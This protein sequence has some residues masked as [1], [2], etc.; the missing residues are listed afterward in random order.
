MWRRN[1]LRTLKALWL[2]FQAIASI[3][4]LFCKSSQVKFLQAVKEL[5]E[6]V[7]Q[8]KMT[9]RI[10]NETLR[11]R[12]KLEVFEK[13]WLHNVITFLYSLI[14]PRNK[15]VIF[16]LETITFPLYLIFV[17]QFVNNAVKTLENL[18]DELD[19]NLQ[20][21]ITPCPFHFRDGDVAN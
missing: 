17:T 8:Q 18:F 10:Y 3:S 20:Y 2:K 14:V 11:R 9:R 15:F 16:M 7:L 4:V 21:S 19:R 5:E 1:S 12:S 13:F 6:E